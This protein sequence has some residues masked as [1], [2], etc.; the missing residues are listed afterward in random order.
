[1]SECEANYDLD[2]RTIIH[3]ALVPIVEKFETDGWLVRQQTTLDPLTVV[4]R[5]S[6]KNIFSTGYDLELQAS[7]TSATYASYQKSFAEFTEKLRSPSKE[8]TNAFM[9]FSHEMNSA[10][11]S[12]IYFFV[13]NHGMGFSNYKGGTKVTKLSGK[14]YLIQSP[15]VSPRTGGGEEASVDASFLLIGNWKQPI[16]EK[17]GGGSESIKAS[18]I[19]NP[20]ASHLQAQ[21]VIIRIECNA[22]LARE[23]VDKLD[24]KKLEDLL[25]N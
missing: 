18:A 21:N 2:V 12:N 17:L 3:D 16:I 20:T 1:P 4:G 5:G 19:L 13:N 9:K 8:T 14:T 25:S 15:Y 24:L 10:I 22:A 6:E 23:I 11:Y 7:A